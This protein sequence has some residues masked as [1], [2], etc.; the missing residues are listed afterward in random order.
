MRAL[1]LAAI[2][3]LGFLTTLPAFAQTTFV[4]TKTADTNDGTCDADCSLREALEAAD[5]A[6]GDDLIRFDPALDGQSI[7]P[8]S[9]YIVNTNVEIDAVAGLS[10]GI[11][12]DAGL[13]SFFVV[14]VFPPS[15]PPNTVSLAGLTFS[16]SQNG[17]L[18][19]DGILTVDQC[20][21]RD[22]TGGA[23]VNEGTLVV[24]NSTLSGNA[25]T[26]IDRS[27]IFNQSGDVTVLNSTF[28][29]NTTSSTSVAAA[30]QSNPS[31]TVTVRNSTF[32]GNTHTL[33]QVSGISGGTVT[34]GNTV[35]ESGSGANLGLG[36]II[37]E[38]FNICDDACGLTGTSDQTSTDPQLGPLADN[39]G[40]TL[41]HT[42]L[43]GSPAIDI[44]GTCGPEDQRGESAPVAGTFNGSAVCDAGAIE[45]ATPPPPSMLVVN[46][47]DGG[48]DGICGTDAFDPVQ[49]CSLREAVAAANSNP[50]ANTITFDPL[51]QGTIV[52]EA[53]LVIT[54]PITIDGVTGDGGTYTSQVTGNDVYGIV[55]T[56]AAASNSVIQGLV[57][58]D[59]PVALR[60]DD[61]VSGVQVLGNFIGADSDGADSFFRNGTAGLVI[62]GGSTNNTIGGTGGIPM[63]GASKGN[64]FGFS[65][66][67][68]VLEGTGTTGNTVIG[69]FFSTNEDG[70]DLATDVIGISINGVAIRDGASN[71]T[72]G[73]TTSDERNVF[74]YLRGD[75]ILIEDAGTTGNIVQGNFIGTD[76]DGFDYGLPSGSGIYVRNAASDN[77]IGGTAAGAGNTIG[78]NGGTGI[79]IQFA[80]TT[81]NTVQGNFI[82]TNADGDNYGNRNGIWILGGA[83][84]NSIG[85][86]A[87]GAANTI[88]HN[89]EQGLI[90]QNT[91]TSNNTIQ[92]NFIGTNAAGADLG[93]G[94]IG[95][96]IL[97]GP[98]DNT[99]GGSGAGEGNTIGF[100]V[101]GIQ[102]AN[103]GASPTGN[104]ILGN[105]IGT[106]ATGANLGN[107]RDGVS[108]GGNITN[109]T[110]GGTDPG[111][112]NTIGFNA[113]HGI[114][115][116]FSNGI[117]SI[118]SDIVVQ[119]NFVGTNA[120]GAD[121]GNGIHGIFLVDDAQNNTIGG[122]ASGEGNTV[123]FN[124][125]SG[126]V[127]S[128]APTASNIVQGNFVG[129]NAA[130][131]NLGN[132]LR[133]IL[134]AGGATNNTIGGANAGE[135]NTVG[136]NA[137]NG[138][139]LE[140]TGTNG[141]VVRGN[142]LGTDATGANLGNTGKGISVASGASN[143][144]IGGTGA[145][146]GNT[147]GFSSQDG[148][149]VAGNGTTG[150]NVLGNFV[151]T[152]AAGDD[153]GNTNFGVTL[154]FGAS[155]NTVGGAASGA[156]NTI[157]FH[158]LAGIYINATSTGNTVLGNF[159][160]TNAAGD[161]L[162]NDGNGVQIFNAPNNT[163]G[164]TVA[165]DGNT[166]ANNGVGINVEGEPAAGNALLG[167]QVFD[168]SSLGIDLLPFGVAA[169]DG[170]MD[171]DVGPNGLQNFPVIAQV[172][173][174]GG[175]TTI[176]YDLDTAAGDYRV[177]F[178]SVTTPDATGNGEGHTFLGAQDATV[179]AGCGEAFQLVLP[180][181]LATTLSVT[182]TA[183]RIDA[184]QASGFGGTSEFSA[185][186]GVTLAVGTIG[187]F[188]FNDRNGDGVQDAG[189]GGLESVTLFLDAN[190]NDELDAGEQSAT[191]DA[192]GAYDLT[193]I[194]AG[195][196]TVKV[197]TTTVP[198]GFVLTT[199]ND[200]QTVVLASQ[201]DFNDADFGFRFEC[202]P[203]FFLDPDAPTNCLPAPPGTF[204][205]MAG[206]TEAEPCV[207]GTFQP[208]EGQTSCAPAPAGRFVAVER[209][210]EAEVCALGTYQP[211]EGQTSC[212]DADPGNFVPAEGAI[213][214]SPC[215]LG[216]FQPE[217]GQSMC[218]PAPV[219][220]YVDME[221]ATSATS[222]PAGTTTDDEGATSA[223][224]CVA[225]T[226]Q[227]F[228]VTKTDDTNDGTCDADCSLREAI[229]AA[230][231][232]LAA[233]A[234]TVR[235][236]PN[237][238][239]TINLNGADLTVASNVVVEGPGARVLTVSGGLS[240]TRTNRV[241]TIA[242][243]A[244]DVRIHGLTIE[245]GRT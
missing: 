32:S 73:G 9:E 243:S 129:T 101:D 28:S 175:T 86:S 60:L 82:G 91:G 57:L 205:A 102:V 114:R 40:P 94:A 111:A 203:G 121:L 173:A 71:N 132:T 211:L 93:N 215:E 67:N 84:N 100:N 225:T 105:Y 2:L 124:G 168:N 207:P 107:S 35:F 83:S 161:D 81:G 172:L 20:T 31:A 144:T 232:N 29:G 179:T 183:T 50:D 12:I 113:E 59:A 110:V 241:F 146:E 192:S 98:S 153:L 126:I 134:I 238:T 213:A 38:G 36:T 27:T 151:G 52:L 148:I 5:A 85:G 244:G 223:S 8:T 25:A 165:D 118:D 77:T 56:G 229:A 218:L 62:T 169:N 196:Y 96:R 131:A 195:T 240:S 176:D 1:S 136:F 190:G 46:T 39:G 41:T 219:G 143:N 117:V 188:V 170:C 6:A 166:I 141:N 237:V 139:R 79:L 194:L 26:T 63:S 234:D 236:A 202:A 22:N 15:G 64:V 53:D 58:G 65:P 99:I 138:I 155:N 112:G 70:D 13:E 90:L 142:F 199:G 208:L 11:T 140:G 159:V 89:S 37:S 217:A 209:A 187:D 191:T 242:G 174:D 51:G 127:I 34:V 235:F 4:V 43:T 222:C 221:E 145:G 7:F 72:V 149:E 78:F 164:G 123:G 216:T 88:G 17:F 16:R 10:E 21:F 154:V 103:L 212:L 167:N 171:A 19:N 220:S 152:N 147:V 239:G 87:A 163:I 186:L 68:L 44:G 47:A 156:E 54:T 49:D 184:G 97:F 180:T 128:E 130:G 182:A 104:Q 45:I 95:V 198:E 106:N 30:I 157:G 3:A 233:E 48:D 61:G 214:Q 42:L 122:A 18:Y 158:G 125:G 66:K 197:D 200:P 227:T 76:L 193:D 92:G 69:N 55:V 185:A 204:V 23:I 150:N 14:Q 228:L 226:A 115:I 33:G 116:G 206:A 189:E 135:G 108:I 120:A 119:G 201:E 181:Q 230:D 210:T 177:E 160:G 224:D 74:G 75:G 80:G 231:A 109:N 24:K 178:F 162:G 245:R 137:L 133:G